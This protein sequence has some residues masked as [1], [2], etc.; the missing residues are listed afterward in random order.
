MSLKRRLITGFLL[1]LTVATVGL[2][3]EV[4]A[5]DFHDFPHN[6][7]E[8]IKLKKL[9]KEKSHHFDNHHHVKKKH[10]VKFKKHHSFRRSHRRRGFRRSLFHKKFFGHH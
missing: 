6:K 4:E 1:S 10:P 5:K 2:T 8:L 7:L 3:S 9:K